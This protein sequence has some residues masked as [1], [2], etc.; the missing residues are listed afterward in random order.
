MKK[1]SKHISYKEAVRSN[2]AKRLGV[3]NT[4]ND[5]QLNRMVYVAEK[6]FEPVRE[7]LNARI[8]VSSFFRC[9]VVN[10]KI[11]GSTSSFHPLGAAID[12]D[13]DPYK[14]TTNREIFLSAIENAEFTEL[15]YEYPTDD[16]LTNCAWVHMALIKGREK[17]RRIKIKYHG[18]AYREMTP[19]EL[20]KIKN[21]K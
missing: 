20:E 1:I 21:A 12:A 2:A 5:Q 8:Y 3:D 19:E 17:E 6:S 9:P 4:P 13:A 15:I 7:D 14:E 10:V 16:E 11:G 18:A